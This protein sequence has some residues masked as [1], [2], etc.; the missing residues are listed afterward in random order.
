[1]WDWE[2]VWQL[3]PVMLG[4]LKVTILATFGGF[5]VAALFGLV[6]AMAARSRWK[7]LSLLVR[8]FTEFI[9]FTPLLVQLFFLYYILPLV[10]GISLS[11]FT[12][13]VIGLGLHYSTYMSE[14][15]RSGIDAVPNGQWEA[16]R[17]LN[18]S[19]AGMWGRVILPQAVPPVIPV[20]GNYL[21]VM[22]KET[23]L[24]SAITLTELLLVAK[25]EVSVTW[26]VFEPY[27][28][29]G[30]LFLL[31][32]FS[33]SLVVRRLELRLNKHRGA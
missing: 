1:M 11:A 29:V 21:I 23:P 10:A 18:F 4:A 25:N 26:K 2:Y 30:V 15:Y 27:T 17:A 19:K 8:G 22:F 13:G 6:L 7:P 14:V 20:M 5:T 24:L 28:L 12:I 31:I 3:L 33:A 32:S 9:R 16:A